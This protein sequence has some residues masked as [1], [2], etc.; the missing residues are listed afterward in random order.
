MEV[1]KE[2][3]LSAGCQYALIKRG[4][5]NR[6]IITRPCYFKAEVVK[7][8]EAILEHGES[9]ILA[10]EKRMGNLHG[11]PSEARHEEGAEQIRDWMVEQGL[12][13]E[14][15]PIGLDRWG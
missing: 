6:R 2:Y 13:E 7:K 11:S 3:G 15:H 4:E 8:C 12:I 14:M 1:A 5:S 10:W 9:I